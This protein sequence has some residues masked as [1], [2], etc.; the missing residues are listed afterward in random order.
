VEVLCAVQAA[1]AKGLGHF[2]VKD[3]SPEIAKELYNEE[4]LLQPFLEG[5]RL[6]DVRVCILKNQNGDFYIAGN[7]FRK[8]VK[9]TDNNFTT[10]YST[11]SSCPHP[12]S[13]L[14]AQEQEDLKQKSAKILTILNGKLRQKYR[15]VTELG[16][17]FIL[18]G[19]DK[20]LLLSEIN[21]LCPG[22]LPIAE[23]IERRVYDGGLGFAKLQVIPSLRG[24]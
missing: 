1:R 4:V 18:V 11:G 7:V 8:S 6:G 13:F 12:I 22:L 5:V 17:D 20:E 3:L 16:A 14:S 15:D 2:L 19:N 10:A 9:S 24:V 23:A 21:H